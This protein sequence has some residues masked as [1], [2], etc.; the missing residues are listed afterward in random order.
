IAAAYAAVDGGAKL[1]GG[2]GFWEDLRWRSFFRLRP[3]ALVVSALVA[4]SFAVFLL[5]VVLAVFAG[6][7][8]PLLL[9]AARMAPGTPSRFMGELW[10]RPEALSGPYLAALAMPIFALALVVLATAAVL[11]IRDR[12][13]LAEGLESIFD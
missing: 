8:F 11:G 5:P 13:R 4:A 12:R 7:L 6:L 9:T 3:A 10:I 2:G 1:H